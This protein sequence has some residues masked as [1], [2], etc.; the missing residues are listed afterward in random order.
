MNRLSFVN[1]L[2]GYY[3]IRNTYARTRT[4]RNVLHEQITKHP[5]YTYYCNAS[6]SFYRPY[7]VDLILHNFKGTEYKW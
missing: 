4:F 6:C 3:H 5:K 2:Y 1:S 7:I